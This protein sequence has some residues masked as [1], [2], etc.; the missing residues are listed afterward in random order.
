[1]LKSRKQE[2]KNSDG[3]LKAEWFW[4][5]GATLVG[6]F[7]YYLLTCIGSF[8]P[9]DSTLS[10]VLRHGTL[11]AVGLTY[12][13]GWYLA[14][15]NQKFADKLMEWQDRFNKC[16][17]EAKKAK[18]DP[19][20]KWQIKKV[21]TIRNNNVRLVS[22]PLI[23]VVGVV[24]LGIILSVAITAGCLT[25]YNSTG[26]QIGEVKASLA[27][28]AEAIENK[29]VEAFNDKTWM[30]LV[31]FNANFDKK[32]ENDGLWDKVLSE[33]VE[34]NA[35]TFI[36]FAPTPLMTDD[37]TEFDHAV[38][39]GSIDSFYSD[40]G[41]GHNPWSASL[42]KNAKSVVIEERDGDNKMALVELSPLNG[43]SLW[44]EIGRAHV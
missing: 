17:A 19:Q 42:L 13:L 7:V 38:T 22:L 8:L 24:L 2:I 29:D 12:S 44:L 35:Q 6:C 28:M 23:E 27:S 20:C 34:V 36:P 3:T 26:R 15:T 1:M 9:Y 21:T 14:K 18:P 39:E 11:P 31:L 25:Y 37:K 30:P 43:V 33:S 40:K 10:L 16:S 32:A 41:W 5:I 4:V